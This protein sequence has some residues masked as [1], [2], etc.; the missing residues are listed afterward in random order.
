MKKA[1]IIQETKDYAM[2]VYLVFAENVKEAKTTL[3]NYEGS[4][5][6]GVRKAIMEVQ[7]QFNGQYI[8]E[9]GSYIE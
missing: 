5:H 2:G 7:A 8:I 1:F 9:L 4:L 3:F 6:G